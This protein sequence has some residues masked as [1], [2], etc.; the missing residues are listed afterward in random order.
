MKNLY[1]KP[2]IQVI[3]IKMSDVCG[4]ASL[5]IGTGPGGSNIAEGKEGNMSFGFESDDEVDTDEFSE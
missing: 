3:T 1:H 2:E 4:N 5:E